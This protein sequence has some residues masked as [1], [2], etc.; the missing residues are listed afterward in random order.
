MTSIPTAVGQI[1]DLHAASGKPLAIMLAGHNGSGKSTLWYKRLAPLL[2]MPLVNA[3]RM[4]M[5]IL[6]EVMPDSPLP[7]WAMT[8]RDEDE[9]WMKV[10]QEGVQAFVARAMIEQV[11]FAME[12]VFSHW[13]P[14]EDGTHASKIDRIREMQD[15]GYFVLLIFVGLASS[16]LSIARVRQRVASGGH[17]VAV[18]KLLTRFPRTQAAICEARSVADVTLCTDNSRD[19]KQAFSV[20]RIETPDAPIYDRRYKGRTT[21][22]EILEWLDVVCPLPA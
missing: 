16:A 5:S 10:A 2:Q 18:P 7:P 12:T 15:A 6:P 17:N 3:D 11:P 14:Q 8:L 19:E 1:L 13:E 4:M 20:C 21:P 22:P 9:G